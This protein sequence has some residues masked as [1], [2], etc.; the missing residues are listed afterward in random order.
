[1]ATFTGQSFSFDV[2]VTKNKGDD[3]VTYT[4]T[5]MTGTGNSV[6]W[7]VTGHT[8]N[9]T[10]YIPDTLTIKAEANGETSEMTVTVNGF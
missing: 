4:V 7:Y 1:M 8:L 6:A 10:G 5:S 2:E 9:V 3:P